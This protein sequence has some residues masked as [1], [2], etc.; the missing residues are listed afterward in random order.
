MAKDRMDVYNHVKDIVVGSCTSQGYR[1]I[2]EYMNMLIED[3]MVLL[4]PT[5][6]SHSNSL[7]NE[8]RIKMVF[9]IRVIRFLRSEQTLIELF[10]FIDDLL[11]R[12]DSSMYIERHK[13]D[14]QLSNI[15]QTNELAMVCKITLEVE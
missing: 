2:Q 11:S 10:S 8:T 3:R 15:N 12:F 5:S 6:E 13:V 7:L 1:F 14:Y 9:E 4:L